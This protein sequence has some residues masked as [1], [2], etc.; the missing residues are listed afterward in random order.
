MKYKRHGVNWRRHYIMYYTLRF[1]VFT[2]L[3]EFCD[4]L[5]AGRTIIYLYFVT[6]E[7]YIIILQ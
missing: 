2:L 6:F 3:S 1:C 4:V 7:R 5:T